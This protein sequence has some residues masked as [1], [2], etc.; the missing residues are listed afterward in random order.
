MGLFN[1]LKNRKAQIVLP[2][3]LLIPTILLVI[4]LLFETTK[5][6]R[7]KIRSQFALDSAAFIELTSYSNFLNAVA[8]VNGAFPFRVFRENMTDTIKK[9]DPQVEGPEEISYYDI[10]RLAGAFPAMA[11][12]N[13]NPKENAGRWELKYVEAPSDAEEY[14][15]NGMGRPKSWNTENPKADESTKYGIN[16][17]ELVKNYDYFFLVSDD[18]SNDD[19][20]NSEEG[21]MSS[22][23]LYIAVYKMFENIYESQKKVYERLT[24]GGEFFRKSFYYNSSSC[25]LSQCGKESVRAFKNYNLGLESIHLEKMAWFYKAK[26]LDTGSASD[27]E[28]LLLEKTNEKFKKFMPLYQFSYLDKSTRSKMK[29]LYTG[30]DV[31]E[32]IVP[33]DNYFGINVK[34][35][36]QKLH[37]RAAVQCTNESN[38]CVWPNPTPK[39]Q[40]RLFP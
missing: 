11:D 2:A 16:K 19:Q 31:R 30:I 9:S 38:N 22:L 39:Y 37:V 8:Y 29:K 1:C 24:E 4:Y 27:V 21:I 36:V 32:P 20:N 18:E 34:K 13:S 25:K 33:P 17:K 28:E 40:V 12:I 26:F 23:A 7:F 3:I 10:F 15:E 6:S 35:Y 5:L 14:L